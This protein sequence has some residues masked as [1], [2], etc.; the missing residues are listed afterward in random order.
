[1]KRERGERSAYRSIRIAERSSYQS[2]EQSSNEGDDIGIQHLL[3]KKSAQFHCRNARTYL[4]FGQS[5][6][7]SDCPSEER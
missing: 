7:E 5:E 1:M 4:I 3:E 2:N 6:I